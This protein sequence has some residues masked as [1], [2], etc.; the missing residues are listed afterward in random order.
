MPRTFIAVDIQP[1]RALLDLIGQL[2]QLGNRFRTVAVDQLHVT[3][4]FLGET[5]DSQIAPIEAIVK[6]IV[7]SRLAF[8]ATL[9][10]LGAFPYARRP[11]VVWVGLDPAEPLRQIAAELD[12]ELSGL[13]FQPEERPLSPHLTLLRVKVRPPESLLSLL[14]EESHTDF[15]AVEISRVNFYQSELSR[16]GSRYTRLATAVMRK[17]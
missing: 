14:A 10:G 5:S 1:T 4:K 2:Q 3:L 16:T 12:R 6:R 9:S 7:E 8:H 13:G 11:A 17:G 15:G